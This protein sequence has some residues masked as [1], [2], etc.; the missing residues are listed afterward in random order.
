MAE[1]TGP[2]LTF[3][4][5]PAV[6]QTLKRRTADADTPFVVRMPFCGNGAAGRNLLALGVLAFLVTL[7][8][9]PAPA[10]STSGQAAPAKASGPTPR[11]AAP[12]SGAPASAKA[13]S[14]TTPAPAP[15]AGIAAS[16]KPAQSSAGQEAGQT[17]A[18][19]PANNEAVSD[20]DGGTGEAVEEEAPPQ[21][22]PPAQGNALARQNASIQR[23]I[24]KARQRGGF[25]ISSWFS[26]A[27]A[28][29]EFSPGSSAGASGEENCDPIDATVAEA[30]IRESARREG[31]SSDLVREVVRKESGFNPCAVSPKGAI[32]M[33]QLMPDTAA[34]LGVDDPFDPRQNID[35]GVRMLKRL[36]D[37]YNGRPDLALAAY[38]AG[39]G[40][41]DANQSVPAY[42]ETQEYV[43]TI[44][45]RVFE[46]PA[47]P[48]RGLGKN[49]PAIP[50]I[51]PVKAPVK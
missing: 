10:Q 15:P 39:E 31:I 8:A 2:T 19:D 4:A 22:A 20:A 36:L 32:G 18:G 11:A 6:L 26:D 17:D 43:S 34:S 1:R 41:V 24:G 48:A 12:T 37:K 3:V 47:K 9:G 49:A 45:K 16:P 40:A 5:R 46:E 44:M 23:Q 51:E 38:N 7:A 30:Y 13:P 29:G 35:G 50:P 27:P 21:T 14:V 25:F 42:E 33:M 28:S